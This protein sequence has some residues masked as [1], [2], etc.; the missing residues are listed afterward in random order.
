MWLKFATVDFQLIQ[1]L[2]RNVQIIHDEA[3]ESIFCI[4][5]RTTSSSDIIMSIQT[6]FIAFWMM[7]YHLIM[8]NTDRSMIDHHIQIPQ[9]YFLPV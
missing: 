9:A 5:A 3:D 1:V 4:I 6:W 7:I 8:Y 2:A